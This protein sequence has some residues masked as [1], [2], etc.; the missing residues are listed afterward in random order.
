MESECTEWRELRRE[1]MDMREK[2]QQSAW[3]D[4]LKLLTERLEKE[5]EEFMRE[6]RVGCLLEGEWF[7]NSLGP[8][9]VRDGHGRKES[10]DREAVS[11]LDKKKSGGG[12]W[13][14]V[15]LKGD[16]KTLCWADFETRKEGR[17]MTFDELT[18]SSISVLTMTLIES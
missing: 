1:Q 2:I 18:E 10:V 17:K 5:A 6:Q 4:S 15:R 16:R 13:R 7:D 11:P 12:R 8:L 9:A 14:Y 3:G